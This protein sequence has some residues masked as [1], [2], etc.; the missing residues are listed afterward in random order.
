MFIRIRPGELACLI[1]TH[2]T[3]RPVAPLIRYKG[4]TTRAFNRIDRPVWRSLIPAVVTGGAP[5]FNNPEHGPDYK[6]NSANQ[7]QFWK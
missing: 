3:V 7:Y 5:A 4:V 1:L 6:D 2:R